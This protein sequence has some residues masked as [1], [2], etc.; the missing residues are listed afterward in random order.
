MPIL[1]RQGKDK[2]QFF[3]FQI[4]ILSFFGEEFFIINLKIYG[5][6]KSKFRSKAKRFYPY[7]YDFNEWIDW[8]GGNDPQYHTFIPIDTLEQGK[9]L[10]EASP[11]EL[12][13]FSPRLQSDFP[14]EADKPKV[15][16]V[17]K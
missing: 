1:A 17:G 11:F 2:G 12:L 4:K 13:E 6:K 3:Y 5:K 16:W 9:S 8:E 10:S 15:Y 14:K 7:F